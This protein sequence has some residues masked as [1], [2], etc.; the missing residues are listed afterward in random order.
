MKAKFGKREPREINPL[1]EY[2]VDDGGDVRLVTIDPGKKK[3]KDNTLHNNF[4]LSKKNYALLVRKNLIYLKRK[5]GNMKYFCFHSSI[6]DM[7]TVV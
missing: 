2:I 6:K 5:N 7:D 1:T 3:M 4:R